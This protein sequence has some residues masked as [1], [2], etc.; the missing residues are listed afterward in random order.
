MG[1]AAFRG[2]PAGCGLRFPPASIRLAGWWMGQLG[3]QASFRSTACRRLSPGFAA[4]SSFSS[5]LESVSGYQLGGLMSR[6]IVRTQLNLA[7]PAFTWLCCFFVS[8]FMF[9]D[10]RLCASVSFANLIDG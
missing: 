6:I 9:V 7:P 10:C 2:T 3:L 1:V 5:R 8:F 4:S